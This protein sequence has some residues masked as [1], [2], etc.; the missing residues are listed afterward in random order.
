MSPI[1]LA[2]ILGHASLAMIQNVYSHL[3]PTEAYE[4]MVRTLAEDE[5]AR[6]ASVVPRLRQWLLLNGLSSRNRPA[7]PSFGSVMG[8]RIAWTEIDRPDHGGRGHTYWIILTE[9]RSP[10]ANLM[11]DS[12]DADLE[13]Q[14]EARPAEELEA[15]HHAKLR[16]LLVNSKLPDQ[17]QQRVEQ[18]IERYH[19]W[20]ADMDRLATLGNERVSDLVTLLNRYKFSIEFDLIFDSPD[21]FLYR[22]G[23]Q[24]KV[25]SSIMEE[26]LPRLVDPRIIHELDGIPFQTGPR[27]AFAAAVFMGTLT[28]PV[29]GAGLQL[30]NKDQDF[31]I[32]RSAYLRASFEAGFPP[33]GTAT[34]RIYLAYVAAECKTNL[35]KTMFQEAAATAHDLRVAVPGSHYFLLCE[36]LDMT[37]ISTAGTDIDEAIIFR[38]KRIPSNIRAG[39]AQR[40]GRQAD[41]EAYARRLQ[42][43][44]V[45]VDRVMRLVSH[46]RRILGVVAEPEAQVL[47]R[48][49]F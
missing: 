11:L 18:A 3:T 33:E 47:D 48:G 34:E 9:G 13:I 32:G 28:A 26:F 17:D 39:Y 42:E 20:V 41:R 22:Q 4:S 31:T 19:Q 27:T 23:G 35:D 44:P 46:L 37:P 2:R 15:P 14:D 24:L 8:H 38:G 10:S 16:E 49:Y 1:M 36:W 7:C 40:A 12:E 25:A 29:R 30:R 5:S 6:L 43:H 21:D 45:R